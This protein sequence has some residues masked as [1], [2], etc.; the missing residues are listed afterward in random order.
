[1]VS[2]PDKFYGWNWSSSSW[3]V[4][5]FSLRCQLKFGRS[6]CQQRQ[7]QQKRTQILCFWNESCEMLLP[8]D[9]EHRCKKDHVW[10]V[11]WDWTKRMNETWGCA[12][13]DT[14]Y[15]SKISVHLN[16]P[17]WGMSDVPGMC[18]VFGFGSVTKW[19]DRP[20]PKPLCQFRSCRVPRL[21]GG[22][23]CC[24]RDSLEPG[25][26]MLGFRPLTHSLSDVITL[27]IKVWNSS[28]TCMIKRWNGLRSS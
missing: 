24:W 2:L 7:Q 21:G 12:R 18:F 28:F 4:S 1:M 20:Q 13:I 27:L 17:L 15:Q 11:G 3:V 8:F 16:H 9:G 25:F 22:C 23:R 5:S 26:L 19:C 14:K 6:Q 10:T